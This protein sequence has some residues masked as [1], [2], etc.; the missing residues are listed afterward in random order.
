MGIKRILIFAAVFLQLVFV[1]SVCISQEN[2]YHKALSLIDNEKLEE[3]LEYLQKHLEEHTE[4]ADAYFTLAL[5]LNRLKEY[6]KAEE[7]L[8]QSL[9][10]SPRQAS[11]YFALAL[12]S[13]KMNAHSKALESWYKFVMLTKN[14]KLKKIAKKHIQLLESIK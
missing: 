9:M 4:D 5:V 10:L 13:E 1:S 14:S 7:Y 12:L 2:Y 6:E 8:N 3:G 11:T